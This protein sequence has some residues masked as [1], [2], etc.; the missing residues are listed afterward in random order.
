MGKFVIRRRINGEFHF[1]LKANNG[2][3]ILTSEGYVNRAACENGI[4]P[5][6]INSPYDERFMRKI[7]TS[8]M[9]YFV[10]KAANGQT[11][12]ISEMYPT[13]RAMEIGINSVKVNAP[14]ATTEDHTLV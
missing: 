4:I 9:H 7:A 14:G 12:G 8:G 1:V 3:I 6:K 2:E 10:L 11:I 13:R 5:V